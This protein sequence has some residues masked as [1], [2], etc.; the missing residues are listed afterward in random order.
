M[1]R[2]VPSTQGM[3]LHEM[4]ALTDTPNVLSSQMD[5]DLV[6]EE[7]AVDIV[8]KAGCVW[9]HHPNIVHGTNPNTSGTRRCGL[10]I[11]YI[12]TTTRITKQ[13]WECAFLLWGEAVEGVNEYSPLPRYVEGE[14][15][16]FRGCEAWV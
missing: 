16:A 2:V 6:D 12:P 1:L 4:K 10:T 15:L 8:L 14:H 11:R 9:V 3:E 13:P 7:R 5:S